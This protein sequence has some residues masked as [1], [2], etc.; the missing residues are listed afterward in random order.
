MQFMDLGDVAPNDRFNF[1]Y[2]GN[3]NT[4]SDKNNNMTL[5]LSIAGGVLA[6]GGIIIGVIFLRKKLVVKQNAT[7]K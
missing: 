1:R 4:L 7:K 5:I 2:V 6:A 3:I